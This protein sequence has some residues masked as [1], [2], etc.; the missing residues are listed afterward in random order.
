[1]LLAA[2]TCLNFFSASPLSSAE[3]L[4]GWYFSAAL[5]YACR[6]DAGLEIR[7]C[8]IRCQIE[9]WHYQSCMPIACLVQVPRLACCLS[10]LLVPADH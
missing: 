7:L 3:A 10:Q 4:S 6:Y 9:R 8:H 2:L 5:L 1:M